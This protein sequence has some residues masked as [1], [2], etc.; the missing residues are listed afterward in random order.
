MPKTIEETTTP[1]RYG[2]HGDAAYRF[3]KAEAA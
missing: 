2:A 3:L 1:R